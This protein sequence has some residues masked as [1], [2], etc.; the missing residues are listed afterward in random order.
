MFHC[1]IHYP[2]ILPVVPATT[3][4]IV[5]FAIPSIKHQGVT[6]YQKYRISFL[7]TI[8]ISKDGK[9]TV[10]LLFSFVASICCGII[11]VDP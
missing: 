10:G 1:K 9:A 3:A 5:K 7:K 4:S 2:K 6:I 8:A 11:S